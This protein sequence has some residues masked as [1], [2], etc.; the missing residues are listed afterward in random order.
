MHTA[1]IPPVTE[2]RTEADLLFETLDQRLVGTSA[3]R[4]M[5]LVTAVVSD[6]RDWWIQVASGDHVTRVVLRVS[7]WARTA[8][9]L[10]ALQQVDPSRWS[11][12]PVVD[13]MTRR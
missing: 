3:E 10:A 8:H 5:A 6:G 9:V 7:R 12:P 4:W 13:V 11:Y 2:D 1:T